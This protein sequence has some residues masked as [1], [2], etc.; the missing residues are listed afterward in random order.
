MSATSPST[1]PADARDA[2]YPGL[3]A[4]LDTLRGGGMIL[5][6]CHQQDRAPSP[7]APDEL[8]MSRRFAVIAGADTYGVRKPDPAHLLRT[9]A[10][11]GGDPARAVMVGDSETDIRAARGPASRRRLLRRLHG[12]SVPDLDRPSSSTI[13]TACP[14]RSA[15]S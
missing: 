12:H 14:T 5:A 4:A 3:L 9:I 1:R 13:M 2:A 10:A 6:V 15:A 11:A 8:D 7:P